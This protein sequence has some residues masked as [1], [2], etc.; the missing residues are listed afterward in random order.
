MNEIEAGQW[1]TEN[2]VCWSFFGS[3]LGHLGYYWTCAA[4]CHSFCFLNI[5]TIFSFKSVVT[6]LNDQRWEQSHW[7]PPLPWPDPAMRSYEKDIQ[8]SKIHPT[9]IEPVPEKTL[10]DF[11]DHFTSLQILSLPHSLIPMPPTGMTVKWAD[12]SEPERIPSWA[13]HLSF[14]LQK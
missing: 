11:S 6:M 5:L 9:F 14:S 13:P 3:G 12:V 1:T 10:T 4:S 2:L 8:A 7:E